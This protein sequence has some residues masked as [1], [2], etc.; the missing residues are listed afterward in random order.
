[1]S[2]LGRAGV[3]E[4]AGQTARLLNAQSIKTKM[5]PNQIAFNTIPAFDASDASGFTGEELQIAAEVRK[6][7]GNE[8][9]GVNISEVFVPVFYG[10]SLVVRVETQAPLTAAAAQRLLAAAKGVATAK[11]KKP[12][13][14]IDL[15]GAEPKI[16]VGRI[17]QAPES[18]QVLTLWSV[19]D[20]V[21]KGAAVNSVQ[22]AETLLK[23]YL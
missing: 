8:K 13:G 3:D 7:L 17:R 15:G 20:N 6:L 12:F 21:R 1:V 4:L 2:A 10:H 16:R 19:A 14:P 22:I 23:P 18:P 11:G 5:F 9:L